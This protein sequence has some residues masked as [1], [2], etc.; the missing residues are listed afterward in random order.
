MLCS[1]TFGSDIGLLRVVVTQACVDEGKGLW[2]PLSRVCQPL[3]HWSQRNHFG[4]GR[5]SSHHFVTSIDVPTVSLL[6]H[7]ETSLNPIVVFYTSLPFYT[8][9]STGNMA[10]LIETQ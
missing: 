4:P 2:F 1:T 10:Y 3:Q 5:R 8:S 7:G 6:S 9:F